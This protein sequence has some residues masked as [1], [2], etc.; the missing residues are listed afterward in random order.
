MKDARAGRIDIVAV[1]KMDR[2]G[3]SLSHLLQI[4]RELAGLQISIVCSSQGIDTTGGGA[5]A[6]LQL[7]VLGAM[8]EFERELIQERT[9]A[10]LASAR[11]RGKKLGRPRFSDAIRAKILELR[12]PA[13]NGRQMSLDEIARITKTSRAFVWNIINGPSKK[14]PPVKAKSAP[15]KSPLHK[16]TVL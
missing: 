10:G 6:N 8:A 7:S 13:R 1:Y 2:L 4:C 12:K 9:A 3:R 11:R 15:G 14:G 16:V 5:A